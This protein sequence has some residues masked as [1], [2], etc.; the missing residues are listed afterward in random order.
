M[1]LGTILSGGTD[2]QYQVKLLYSVVMYNAELKLIDSRLN[3][4]QIAYT[5]A[6]ISTP[7]E[8]F[9]KNNLGLQI[10]SLKKRKSNLEKNVKT[11]EIISAWCADFTE[12]LSG[13]IGTVEIP[14]ESANIQIQPGY[15]ENAIYDIVRDGQLVPAYNMNTAA[16]YYNLA[17]LPGWQKWKPLFRYA[18]IDSINSEANTAKITLE[19]IKSTQQD[20][21]INQDDIISDV[22][23]EYMECNSAAS[24][25]YTHLTLPTN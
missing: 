6:P 12:D 15:E 20:L 5:S 21:N 1:G 4:L 3:V 22:E 10:E 11:E 8:I 9:K 18:I 25:S 23:I 16:W 24:V 19:D 2:G 17:M 7:R 13:N 14:G